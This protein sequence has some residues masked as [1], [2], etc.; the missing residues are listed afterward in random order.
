[1]QPDER[2][3]RLIGQRRLVRSRSTLS[4]RVR[5][6]LMARSDLEELEQEGEAQPGRARLVGHQSPIILDQR[7]GGD[8]SLRLPVPD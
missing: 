5:Q 1:M 3:T 6:H 2:L 4:R 7:P 8:Q